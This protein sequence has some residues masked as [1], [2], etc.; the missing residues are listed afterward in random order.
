M[1]AVNGESMQ[2]LLPFLTNTEK[3]DFNTAAGHHL[4][5]CSPSRDSANPEDGKSPSQSSQK[6]HP[7]RGRKFPFY[8]EKVLPS[9]MRGHFLNGSVLGL[10]F[11][12]FLRSIFCL[13]RSQRLILLRF[14]KRRDHA[15][16]RVLWAYLQI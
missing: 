16:A 15:G 5:C 10:T 4:I 6:T 8:L 12:Y 2:P 1:S 9:T 3:H 11:Y 14:R 7:N 13:V